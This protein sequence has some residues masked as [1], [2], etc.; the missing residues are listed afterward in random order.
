MYNYNVARC[1]RRWPLTI[2]F[3][4]LNT[5][6]INSQVIFRENNNKNVP[7]RLFIKELGMQL[8]KEHQT[9]RMANPRLTNELR[10]S[11]RKILGETPEP[12]PKKLRPNQQ[13]RCTQ[14]PRA[15]DRKSKNV[16]QACSTFLCLEHALLYCSDCAK[17]LELGT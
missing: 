16:C 11:I 3:S 12:K 7:R 6:S 17:S 10:S 5:A 14:C 9:Q 1:C 15:R 8:V 4:L 2:F 13:G